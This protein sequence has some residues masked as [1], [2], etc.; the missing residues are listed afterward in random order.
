MSIGTIDRFGG[1]RH[2]ASNLKPLITFR[3]FEFVQ[4]HNRS[5]PNRDG[6]FLAL[7]V[8]EPSYVRN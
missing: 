6:A 8:V 7:V 4:R 5:V 3:T 2:W 1:F